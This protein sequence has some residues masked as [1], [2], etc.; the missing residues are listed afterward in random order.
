MLQPD[1]D[2]FW[3]H[4]YCINKLSSLLWTLSGAE[5]LLGNFIFGEIQ[6]FFCVFLSPEKDDAAH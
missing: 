6:Q 5:G 4:A 3:I 2:T 1:N